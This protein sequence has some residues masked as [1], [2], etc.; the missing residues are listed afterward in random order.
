MYLFLYS[1]RR[2]AF[3]NTIHNVFQINSKMFYTNLTF[4]WNLNSQS[5]PWI[6]P[7]SNLT[8]ML[9]SH[10]KNRIGSSGF[11]RSFI[12]IFFCLESGL[13]ISFRHR[14]GELVDIFIQFLHFTY[15]VLTRQKKLRRSDCRKSNKELQDQK[16][17]KKMKKCFVLNFVMVLKSSMQKIR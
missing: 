10:Y 14:L 13:E 12:R 9:F 8:L 11:Y 16:Y 2:N 5:I 17:A 1:Y 3:L 15:F 7:K 6:S 4:Y